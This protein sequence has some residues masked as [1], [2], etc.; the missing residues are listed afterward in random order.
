MASKLA[1]SRSRLPVPY[2]C[3]SVSR[4]C[5][6][7]ALFLFTL[8]SICLWLLNSRLHYDDYWQPN[9]ILFK[10]TPC[11]IKQDAMH[12][13]LRVDRFAIFFT[14]SDRFT[15]KFAVTIPTHLYRFATPS[16]D[17]FFAEKSPWSRTEWSE[18]QRRTRPSKQLPK[19]FKFWGFLEILS[20]IYH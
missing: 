12:T 13:S 8:S 3:N 9:C 11:L 1:V 2:A 20:G 18:P 7:S 5:S 6:T 14:D 4:T 15:G 19:I 16:C 17:I 10:Y